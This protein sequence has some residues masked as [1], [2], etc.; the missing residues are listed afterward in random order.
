MAKRR[1]IRWDRVTMVFG[2]LFLLILLICVCCNR[3]EEPETSSSEILY[4]TSETVPVMTDLTDAVTEPPAEP[5]DA[6]QR[7]LVIVIDPGHGG[8]DGGATDSDDHPTRFEK[9]DNLALSLA[10]RDALSAYPHI[11]VIMTRET[12]VFVKLKDRCEISNSANADFF[13]S[14]H[15]NSAKSG[16][17]VE[18][19]INNDSGGDN[20]WDKLLAEYIME[21]LDSVG[22]TQNRG[23]KTGYRGSTS[24]TE[25]NNYYVNR[26]TDCPSCL[27][28]MGFMSSEQDNRNFDT[29][30]D[31]YADAIA[32]AVIE[33]VSD[34]GLYTLDSPQ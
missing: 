19:W 13:I 23:I 9:N 18:I 27:V 14:L 33:L 6:G 5:V 25:G 30:L 3:S 2:P 34:K 16:S 10:V 21:L 29:R 8:D 26:Y 11:N 12:D 31:D 24:N 20:S 4:S 17:G 15:R 28:E 1:R 22:I 32:T 7:D